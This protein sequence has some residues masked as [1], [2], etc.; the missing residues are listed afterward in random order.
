M[1]NTLLLN[2]G[3]CSVITLNE[4]LLIA[5]GGIRN[6]YQH[7]ENSK[8]CIKVDR[9]SKGP[10]AGS[11]LAEARLF[12]KLMN[13]REQKEFSAIS[14]YRGRVETSLGFG[15]TFDL[16]TDENTERPSQILMK[17]LQEDQSFIQTD[18]FKKAL[19]IFRRDLVRDA[20][21]CQDIRPWNICVQK[22]SN[23]DLKLILIDGVG[24]NKKQWFDGIKLFIQLK[25]LYYFFSKYIYPENRLLQ[26]YN[27]RRKNYSWKPGPLFSKNTD[28][29]DEADASL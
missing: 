8:I 16:I 28:V 26:F 14:N 19:R 20:V 22:R 12:E 11:T 15:A 4:E 10:A 23:G 24:H 2:E 1:L 6:I 21:L 3:I 18:R 17:I 13:Q 5:S 27:N 29:K 7:P 25:M 9:N